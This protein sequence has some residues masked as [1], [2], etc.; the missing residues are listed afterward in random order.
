MEDGGSP[1]SEA[2]FIRNLDADPGFRIVM[3]LEQTSAD[4]REPA[5]LGNDLHRT[6]NQTGFHFNRSGRVRACLRTLDDK[7]RPRSAVV[8]DGLVPRKNR[9]VEGYGL[10]GQHADLEPVLCSSE[11]DGCQR[12]R[13]GERDLE[14]IRPIK[15]CDIVRTIGDGRRTPVGWIVPVAA[16]WISSPGGTASKRMG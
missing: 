2:C 13:I 4:F 3:K 1:I 11:T 5:P 15:A 7:G 12:N 8:R 14:K 9:R 6:N 10:I 16:D